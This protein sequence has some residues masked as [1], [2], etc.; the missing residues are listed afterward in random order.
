MARVG[1]QALREMRRARRRRAYEEI[2]WIDAV[3]RVY[4]IALFSALGTS[5]VSG[6]VGG[7]PVTPTELSGALD[8]G[9][10]VGG[11][12]V[13]GAIAA[14][15]RSG[16][17]GGPLVLLPADVSI[18]LLAPISRA[19]ALRGIAIRQLRFSGFLGTVV[20][21]IAGNLAAQ[22]LP[23][24]YLP[25]VI[26]GGVAGLITGLAYTGSA[27]VACGLRAGRRL[28]GLIAAGV[29]G[30]SIA[31]L[32]GRTAT[33]PATFAGR[34][35]MLPMHG[36]GTP[37]LALILLGLPL[38]GLGFVGG[39]SLEAARRQA[40]LAAQ[41]RFAVTMQDVRTVILLRRQL[42]AEG[43]RRRPWLRVSGPAR[44]GPVWRRD[45]QG[46]LRWPAPR[47]VRVLVLGAAAGVAASAA[48]EGTPVLVALAGLA[49]LVAALDAVE[50]LA[51]EDDHPTMSGLLPHGSG[52]LTLRHLAVPMIVVMGVAVV[53]VAVGAA[54]A[55]AGVAGVLGI[56]LVAAIPATVGAVIGAALSV[57][58]GAAINPLEVGP[59]GS[60]LAVAR[61]VGPP[62]LALIGVV[63]LA[64][65]RIAVDAHQPALAAAAPV[66]V[67][68]VLVSLA[69][70]AAVLL[71]EA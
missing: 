17:R 71:R 6:L 67:G 34:V 23:G 29:L 19:V 20:G 55:P 28:A 26:S 70:G 7:R 16:G 46:V 45:W 60:V 21:M 30:W 22:R 27:L 57:R 41:L 12:V 2:D 44:R 33:S 52:W 24:A 1:I 68:A 38:A 53:G 18:V 65:A 54:L 58:G 15:L 35:A 9:P 36:L 51:Q 62:L 4:V 13:A 8:F 25:W 32:L 50:G 37:V 11:L 31:D 5:F 3:Y 66:A 49:L 59:F 10:A 61:I 48:W 47:I 40:G 14:G 42:S 39:T 56:G 69:V 43:P 63:P 64:V